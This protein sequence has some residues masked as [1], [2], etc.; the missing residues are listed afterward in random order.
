MSNYQLVI[1]KNYWAGIGNMLKGF[2]SAS[3]ISDNVLIMN[4]PYAEQYAQ[5]AEQLLYSGEEL[6]AIEE[7]DEDVITIEEPLELNEDD[8]Y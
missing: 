3:S 5:Q 1:R 4:N 6:P 7:D 8:I 2:I